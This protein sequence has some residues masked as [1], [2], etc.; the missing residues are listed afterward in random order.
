MA[1]NITAILNGYNRPQNL[2]IQLE[3]L[4]TQS[5]APKDVMLWYNKGDVPQQAVS[6]YV[7]TANCNHNFKFHG[8]FAFAL[9]AQTEYIAIFD[10]DTIP[11]KDW[12]K[13]CLDTYK[14]HPGILG[15][16]GVRLHDN[17]YA[18][19]DKIGGN[20]L[21][22]NSITEVDLV[23]HAWFF[24][25]DCLRRFWAYDPISWENG[26]DIQ[27]SFLNQK[28]GLKTY[29]PPHP[30]SNRDLWGSINSNLGVDNVAN[31][32]KHGH[33]HSRVRHQLVVD[34]I[35]LGWKPLFTK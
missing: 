6:G 33:E 23:G 2:P 26:E 9:L 7:K 28:S 1:S 13:N 35:N 21:K 11:G 15:S 30:E 12:F 4:R 5:V 20:G 14:T 19:H 24:H 27:F 16:A 32:V 10:D 18:H 34:C 29:V 25:R 31:S 22:N 8:R 17:V 3:A